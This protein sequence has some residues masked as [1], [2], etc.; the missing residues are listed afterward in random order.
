MRARAGAGREVRLLEET[1]VADGE[2][3][4][5][6]DLGRRGIRPLCDQHGAGRRRKVRDWQRYEEGSGG[7]R[8]HLRLVRVGAA[9]VPI[10]A[11][12]C[13]V[14]RRAIQA[15]LRSVVRTGCRLHCSVVVAVV[16]RLRVMNRAR[17]R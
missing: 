7:T 13:R 6:D 16:R 8:I 15:G 9:A 4:L 3:D 2:T 12:V 10:A 1:T 5:G 14:A 11:T 17:G